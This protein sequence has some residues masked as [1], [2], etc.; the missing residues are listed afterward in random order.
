LVALG[1]LSL[2]PKKDGTMLFDNQIPHRLRTGASADPARYALFTLT[3]M[4]H[5]ETHCITEKPVSNAV[6]SA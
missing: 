1:R 3:G 4:H 2:R 5:F 6:F